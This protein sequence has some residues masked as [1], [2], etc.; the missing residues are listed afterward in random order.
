MS[1]ADHIIPFFYGL[2]TGFVMSVLL[3]AIFFMLIQAGVKHGH[4]KGF[5]IA[6]G[7]ISGDIIFVF[8][9]IAFTGF[10]SGFLQK[11]EAKTAL[12]GGLV[13]ATMG[14]FTFLQNRKSMEVKE[15]SLSNTRDFFLKPFIINFLNPANAAWWLGLYS[16]PPAVYYSLSQKIVFACGAILMV[17]FTEV[18]VAYTA[19]KLKKLITPHL[20]KRIDAIVGVVFVIVGLRL[21]AKGFGWF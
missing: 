1:F 5:I 13:I 21:L 20:L 14:V 16:L 6:A 17:Y 11:H 7:V 12:V 4:K 2:G 10:I 9:T 15:S 8:L 3:G 18:G 19:S